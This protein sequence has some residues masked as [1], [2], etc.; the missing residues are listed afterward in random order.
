MLFRSER[1]LEPPGYLEVHGIA[2]PQLARDGRRDTL[3]R[4]YAHFVIDPEGK[5]AV[6]WAV[7]FYPNVFVSSSPRAISWSGYL[8]RIQGLS[9]NAPT[10]GFYSCGTIWKCH[11]LVDP[12]PLVNGYIY[13]TSAVKIDILGDQS[14]FQISGGLT[15]VDGDGEVAA[16]IFDFRNQPF[17]DPDER[18]LWG[19]L[20]FLNLNGDFELDPAS[21]FRLK[22]IEIRQK[23]IAIP[24]VESK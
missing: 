22:Q 12:V 23:E 3:H 8:F 2:A 20:A 9:G 4:F 10:I 15:G 7:R 17:V 14:Q 21:G 5:D 1:Q 6:S 13:K 24:N 11:V 16:P 19:N 18:F